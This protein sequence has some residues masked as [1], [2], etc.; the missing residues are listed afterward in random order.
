MPHFS[1]DTAACKYVSIR[2]RIRILFTY[3]DDYD[4]DDDDDDDDDEDARKPE[5]EKHMRCA[6]FYVISVFT[7]TV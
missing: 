3:R 6:L 4:Y 5:A 1:R 7:S 2:I